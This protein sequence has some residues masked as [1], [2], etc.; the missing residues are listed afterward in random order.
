MLYLTRLRAQ[1]G[2]SDELYLEIKK[3]LTYDHQTNFT[4]LEGFIGML[5]VHLKL[6]VSEEIHRKNFAKFQLFTKL[7]NKHFIA[8]VGARLKP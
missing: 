7:G 8:W 2:I 1:Y 6:E 3:A 5:P 4:G